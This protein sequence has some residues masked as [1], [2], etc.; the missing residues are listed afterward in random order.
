MKTFRFLDKY[1]VLSFKFYLLYSRR[2]IPRFVI[3]DGFY[4]K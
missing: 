4:I 2:V 3:N 1:L